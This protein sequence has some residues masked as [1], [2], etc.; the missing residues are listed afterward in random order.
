MIEIIVASAKQ[1]RFHTLQANVEWI[2][3]LYAFVR[4]DPGHNSLES[5][6]Y[7]IKG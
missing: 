4:K 6:F 2:D 3:F 5:H 1:R 7:S